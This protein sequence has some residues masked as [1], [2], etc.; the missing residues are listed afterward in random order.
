ME[1][2]SRWLLLRRSVGDP[3]DITAHVCVAPS[4]TTLQDPVQVAGRRRTM[5][6]CFKADKGEVGPDHFEV[7]SC[8]GRH[9]HIT[10]ACLARAFLAVMRAQ[11]GEPSAELQKVGPPNRPS[12]LALFKAQRGLPSA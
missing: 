8:Q 6:A 3:S 7:R 4:E 5:E 12:S 1:E 9:R 11:A 10:L 2:W